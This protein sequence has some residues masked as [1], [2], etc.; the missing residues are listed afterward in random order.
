RLFGQIGIARGTIAIVTLYLCFF[1][2]AWS[3]GATG[4]ENSTNTLSIAAFQSKVVE[5][6]QVIESFRIEG[7]VCA[8]I[9][10]LKMVVLQD[11][12]GA[13][14][15]ELPK[16]DTAIGVGNWLAIEGDHCS[17]SRGLFGI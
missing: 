7:V 9:P 6:G 4:T 12:S 17:L 11:D 13:V 2:T 1:I 3:T 8:V 15:L 5:T 14:L 16:W 10:K